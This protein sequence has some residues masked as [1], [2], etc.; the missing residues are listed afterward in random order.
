MYDAVPFGG[1]DDM[2]AGSAGASS[3]LPSTHVDVLAPWACPPWQGLKLDCPDEEFAIVQEVE[4]VG[5]KH[6]TPTV[7]TARDTHALV[8]S[9]R[10][11]AGGAPTRACVSRKM[12]PKE[13][14]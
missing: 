3:L 5:L 14:Q 12:L 10:G 8:V 9:R 6:G 1:E 11:R 4:Q 13:R 7:R 2:F